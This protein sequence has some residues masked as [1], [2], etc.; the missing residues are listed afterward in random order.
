MRRFGLIGKTLKHS[1]S[2]TW[3]TK[4]FSEEGIADCSYENYELQSVDQLQELISAHPDIEGLNITIPYKEGVLKFLEHS[5]GLV[6]EIGACNCIKIADGIIS[7]YN[8]DALAF[9]QSLGSN[10]LPQHECAL[11]LGSGG[12]SKAVQFALKKMNIDFLVVTR[13]KKADYIGYEDLGQDVIEGH[14][15]IIN[16][17]PLGTYPNVDADPSIPYQ[18]ISSRHL[19]FDLVYNPAKS[20][21]LQQGEKQGAR[22]VNGYE[23]LVRQ[24][25]ESWRIWNERGIS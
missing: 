21:F 11:V 16:T 23:M 3:F 14:Q 25:E 5:D 13:N 7:G 22:I 12:A 1:F 24:A 18:W 10:L 8:T 9:Q 19:L 2:K 6:K 17:T 15:V 4:K 20:K